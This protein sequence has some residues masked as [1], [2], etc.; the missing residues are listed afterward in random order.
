MAID[1]KLTLEQLKKLRD[2]AFTQKSL[3]EQA[4]ISSPSVD[5]VTFNNKKYSYAD[6]LVEIDRLN[7]VASDYQKAYDNKKPKPKV[8]NTLQQS[9]LRQDLDTAQRLAG[10]AFSTLTQE[11]TVSPST[12]QPFKERYNAA[13]QN[14]SRAENAAIKGG[15]DVAKTTTAT[16]AEPTTSVA[17]TMTRAEALAAEKRTGTGTP[18]PATTVKSKV[19]VVKGGNN[20]EVTTYMDGR[21][22]EKVLGPSTLPDTAASN[23]PKDTS[24]KPAAIKTYVDEQ[25]KAKGLVDTPANRK[26]LRAEYQASQTAVAVTDNSWEQIFINNNPSKA[27]YLTDLDRNK[28]PQ[29]FAILKEY[30]LPR[31]LTVEEQAA[32][33][34]KLDGTDFFQ[35]LSISGK[36]REIKN[37]VGELGFDSTDFTRFV[38]TA[39]N[40]GYT[41]NR[42]KQE[43]YKEVFKIGDDGKYVNPTAL[44]RATKSADYLN[45]V[46]TARA[47]FNTSGANQSAVQSVLTGGITTEDFQRQQREIAKKRYPHLAD[48]ID[49][50]VSLESLAGNFQT[51]AAKLL[52]VDPNSI[53]MSSAN[54]EVA[55]NF[56]EEGKKRVM[57]TGE[58]DKLLRTDSRYGWEKT[59]NAKDEARG[60][61]AS[62]VQAFGRII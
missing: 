43:T 29:L 37:V 58:W 49:Q 8:D 20:V 61:A 25:L 3:F 38:H 52:E 23:L 40:M 36:V 51:T 10:E 24:G 54:Y 21:V 7:G 12:S 55:L 2:D 39:I 11:I 16:I 59:N 42:L 33:A 4:L 45:V 9:A 6:A 27:W 17:T 47:Y 30:A 53:D 62:L 32:F 26:T 57:T 5:F 31:P 44:A 14:L 35:E 60:L 22:S 48:L 41:G 1:P 34:A 15:L 56:G 50:G 18:D 13:L 46:N 19:T 28:Y